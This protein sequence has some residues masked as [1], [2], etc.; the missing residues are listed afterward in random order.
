SETLPEP[1][2]AVTVPPH[3]PVR[4]FGVETTIPAGSVSVTA[5]PVSAVDAFGLVIVNVRL[6]EPLTGIV[7]APNAFTIDG[8]DET[9]RLAE[10]V[11]RVPPFVDVTLPV[12]LV[13]KPATAPV[14]V[15]L[16]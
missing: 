8:A 2:V 11:W 14:T 3:A 4:P 10:A 5:T 16:N 7:A 12:V 1:A 15:T 9:V 6:V 13:Y